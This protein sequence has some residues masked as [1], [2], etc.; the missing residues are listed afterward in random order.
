MKLKAGRSSCNLACS[1]FVVTEFAK[2]LLG[3]TIPK[4]PSSL[5][6]RRTNRIYSADAG[7]QMKWDQTAENSD[8]WDFDV[9]NGRKMHEVKQRWC[10]GRVQC[11]RI[12]SGDCER[13]E[14]RNCSMRRV[15]AGRS[16][17][18]MMDSVCRKRRQSYFIMTFTRKSRP[19]TWFVN[20]GSA[21]M[22]TCDLAK[23]QVAVNWRICLTT[24]ESGLFL[25]SLTKRLIESEVV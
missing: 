1:N 18:N 17:R 4:E 2:N 9:I 23:R 10:Q 6:L 20:V 24:S 16:R 3:W 8:E 5:S 19:T 21:F 14:L 15:R 7:R 22:N 11:S 12:F 25:S 13:S